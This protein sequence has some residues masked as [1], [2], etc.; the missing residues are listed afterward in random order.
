VQRHELEAFTTWR[1]P[2][3]IIRTE[4]KPGIDIELRHAVENSLVVNELC[5]G[6][7]RPLLINLRHLQSI[8]SEARAYFAARDRSSFV[9]AFGFLVHSRFQKMVGNIFIQFNR[10][11]VPVRLFNDE[12]EAISWLSQFLPEEQGRSLPGRN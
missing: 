6:R 7:L 12:Q 1:T 8:S 10:P 4:A 3:G 5:R 11:R 9:N 2:E